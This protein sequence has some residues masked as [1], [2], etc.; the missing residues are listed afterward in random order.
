MFSRDAAAAGGAAATAFLG[1]GA[2][3][4]VAFGVGGAFATTTSGVGARAGLFDFAFF[5]GFLF[6]GFFAAFL[7]AVFFVAFFAVFLA[8]F[9]AFLATPLLLAARCL[10]AAFLVTRGAA[11]LRAFFAFLY[12]LGDFFLAFA[13]T[14]SFKNSAEMSGMIKRRRVTASLPRASRIPRKPAFFVPDCTIRYRARRGRSFPIPPP[15]V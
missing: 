15:A 9:F 10:A 8:F 4:G 12:F 2:A 6:A 14:N 5:A 11:V 1:F 13:T 7:A 3:L